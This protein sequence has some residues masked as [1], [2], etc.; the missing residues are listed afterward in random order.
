MKEAAKGFAGESQV[1]TALD[2]AHS[3]VRFKL[4]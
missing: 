1:D 4:Y 2:I 3:N